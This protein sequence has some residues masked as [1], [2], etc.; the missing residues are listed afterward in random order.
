MKRFVLSIT[1]LLL[2]FVTLPGQYLSQIGYKVKAGLPQF[3]SYVIL[4][5]D[6]QTERALT[7]A[8][9]AQLILKK[10][11]TV[12]SVSYL[13]DMKRLISDI[14]KKKSNFLVIIL[15]DEE[16]MNQTTV[17]WVSQQLTP[18]GIPLIT[19]RQS[20]TMCGALLTVSQGEAELK[21]HLNKIILSLLKL[22]LPEEF[23]KDCTIDVE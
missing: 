13:G 1:L 2:G 18:A 6:K 22:T 11:F 16:F 20:D 14:I 15:A 12:Y 8:K 7:E 5:G 10:S 17:R 23:E 4:A 21:T 9:S 3:D 19:T